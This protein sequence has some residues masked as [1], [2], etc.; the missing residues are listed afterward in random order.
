MHFG[1]DVLAL[2]Y[3]WA[4]AEILEFAHLVTMLYQYLREWN[5]AAVAMRLINVT[6]SWWAQRGE[7]TSRDAEP[8]RLAERRIVVL[9]DGVDSGTDSST[10][11]D[12]D[13]DALGYAPDDVIRFSY[14]GGRTPDSTDSIADIPAT[15]YDRY[16]ADDD[17]R[18]SGQ[19]LRELLSAI[20][21]AAPGVPIDFIGHGQGGLV[22][23]LA[24]GAEEASSVRSLVTIGTPHQGS[25][26]A[27]GFVLID[28]SSLGAIAHRLAFAF[29][30][31]PTDPD[32]PAPG[33]QIEGSDLLHDLDDQT[34]PED[35]NVTSIGGRLDIV[36]TGPNT[37]LPGANNVIVDW[38]TH[39]SLP[40]TSEVLREVALAVHGMAPTCQTLWN[41]LTDHAEGELIS[42][43]TDAL[44]LSTFV[45]L[46]LLGEIIPGPRIIN[47]TE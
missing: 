20:E 3:A 46:E 45:G 13:F 8:P 32:A 33:Q 25:D 17:L 11:E 4:R 2:G 43:G 39:G 22:A 16:D 29:G 23:R 42:L 28:H 37:R 21:Q 19:R 35:T 7:C 38:G 9:V 15:E 36:V 44:S 40:G 1:G 24:L 47:K 26:A 27:T 6:L 31:L 14:G 10:L 41:M 12:L 30:A 5:S 18:V 34:L